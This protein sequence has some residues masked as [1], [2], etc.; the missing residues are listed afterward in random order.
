[1]ERSRNGWSGTNGVVCVCACGAG[2]R[3]ERWERDEVE[4]DMTEKGEECVELDEDQGREW[5]NDSRARYGGVECYRVWSRVEA[6]GTEDG[7]K[8]KN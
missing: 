5:R 3:L 2:R 4:Q 8:Y 1:M 7:T 6:R